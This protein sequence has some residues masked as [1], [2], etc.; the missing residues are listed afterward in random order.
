MALSFLDNYDLQA[1]DEFK[2]HDLEYAVKESLIRFSDYSL[3]MA[4]KAHKV[5][6][7]SHMIGFMTSYIT[8]VMIEWLGENDARSH[9]H[10]II[11]AIRKEAYHVN[12]L[13][14]QYKPHQDDIKRP[15][16]INIFRKMSKSA[17]M[18]N[19]TIQIQKSICD[20]AI[21]SGRSLKLSGLY[22]SKGSENLFTFFETITIA[23]NESS[24]LKREIAELIFSDNN[25]VNG[26]LTK[27]LARQIAWLA[28]FFADLDKDEKVSD[29]MDCI[30][31]VLETLDFNQQ[32]LLIE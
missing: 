5:F 11:K 18:V 32:L 1:I 8:F 19:Q 25:R 29:I 12:K 31:G 14:D 22:S 9:K 26:L 10:D 3:E 4:I 15:E 23:R 17:S 28:G 2:L 20:N 21:E 27:Q 13:C 24:K 16:R 7:P 30:S 6:S